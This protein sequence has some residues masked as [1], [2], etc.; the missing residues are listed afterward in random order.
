[1]WQVAVVLLIWLVAASVVAIWFGIKTA[2]EFADE[3]AMAN[4]VSAAE[5]VATDFTT[6]DVA[7]G[8][9]D[10]QRLL[11]GTTERYA[12]G[13]NGDKEAYLKNLAAIQGK[14]TGTVTGSGVID[15]SPQTQTVHVLVTVR[16][17][18]STK[19]Q[20]TPQ[21]RDYRME[22]TMIDQ[23]WL[24]GGWKADAIEFRS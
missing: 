23:S 20:P 8:D 18:V 12:A 5:E 4:A 7:S 17:Q 11:K 24:P 10:T 9:Q 15:Y 2:Q 6:L 19:D 3:H 16:A 1:V 13:F 22:L 14:S 21:P